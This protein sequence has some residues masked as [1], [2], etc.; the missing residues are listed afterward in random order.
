MSVI[1]YAEA[2]AFLDDELS[3]G[4]LDFPLVCDAAEEFVKSYCRRTFDSA[5]YIEYHDGRGLPK[6]LLNNYPITAL[7]RLSIGRRAALRVCNTN[8]LTIASATVNSTGVVLTYN[9]T[10]STF[11]FADYASLTLLQAAI[12]ATSGWS[13]E[14]VNAEDACM[15]STELCKSYGRSCIDSQWVDL[16]VPNGAEYDFV[17]DDGAGII[18]YSGSAPAGGASVRVDYTAGYTADTMPED[19]K[20]AVKVLVKDW[21]EKRAE[22]SFN[23]G[24]YSVGGMR[25]QILS[26]VP[27]EAMR[28]LDSYRRFLS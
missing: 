13:A 28:I 9:G 11:L 7:T 6:L 18:T 2:E 12:T 16:E 24:S 22:S 8:A 25:K 20:L 10:A 14:L 4:N 27:P 23:L 17:L 1:S 5:S 15:L 19:L 26:S 3:P 21:W